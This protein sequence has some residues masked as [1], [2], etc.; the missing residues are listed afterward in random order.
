ME[1]EPPITG[2]K[3]IEL[4]KTA[5]WYLIAT[6]MIFGLSVL[7]VTSDNPSPYYNQ[8]APLHGGLR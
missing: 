8:M 6:A 3:F 4:K 1:V 5:I 2:M 7:G